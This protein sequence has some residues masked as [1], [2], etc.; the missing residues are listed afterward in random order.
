VFNNTLAKNGMAQGLHGV[1]ILVF[2]IAIVTLLISV[3]LPSHR[4]IM[5]QQKTD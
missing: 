2:A 5:A 3:L 1:Y 4:S